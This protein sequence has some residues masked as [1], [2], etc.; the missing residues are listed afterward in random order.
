MHA[1]IENSATESLDIFVRVLEA[2]T[3]PDDRRADA[4]LVDRFADFALLVPIRDDRAD[5]LA[6]DPVHDFTEPS[7]HRH[8]LIAKR[9]KLPARLHFDIAPPD[10]IALAAIEQ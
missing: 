8:R 1:T 6:L 10:A 4:S 7:G 3:S 9:G 2:E 5:R